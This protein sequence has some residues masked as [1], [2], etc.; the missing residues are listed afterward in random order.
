VSVEPRRWW[1]QRWIEVLEHAG[2]AHARRV[3][4]GQALARRG[5]VE[6]LRITPG[7]I[8]GTVGDERGRPAR[9]ELLWPLPDDSAWEAAVE[10]LGAE[11]RFTAAL[12][13]G[14]LPEGLDDVLAEVGIALF[15]GPG[16]VERRCSCAGS[17]EPCPHA[18]A[19]HAAAGSRFERDPFLLLELRG[20]G[21]EPLLQ[22]LR[23][24][25]DGTRPT[26]DPELDLSA[27]LF[28]ARGDLDAIELHPA[29]VS[30]PGALV[31]HLGPPP[32]VDD[33]G[34]LLD[35]TSRAAATA[36]RLAAG[37]GTDAAE[38][39]LLLAELRAQRVATAASLATALGRDVPAVRAE[40]DRLFEAGSVMRTG[41]G[42]VARYR[43]GTSSPPT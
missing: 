36:W 32:G 35:L 2:P 33:P 12:L 24:D 4:R 23:A 38:E 25:R 29:P 30:D 11:V 42:D 3:Q 18:I 7:R 37:D 20:R 9:V 21:R 31:A 41:T 40:L 43:A 14:T 8:T 15:P 27:G 28:G 26:P 5:V 34:P 6:D 17:D 16:D 13:E 39:E 19:V 10:R 22:A 1:S